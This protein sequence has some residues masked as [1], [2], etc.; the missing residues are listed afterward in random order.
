MQ[1]QGGVRDLRQRL[2]EVLQEADRLASQIEQTEGRAR[3]AARPERPKLT[4]IRGGRAVLVAPL[5]WV[6]AQLRDHASASVGLAAAG[7]IGVPT[8]LGVAAPVIHSGAP[9]VSISPRISE[10]VDPRPLPVGLT[11]SP[12][13]EPTPTVEVVGPEAPPPP[14]LPAPTS[15]LTPT[16]TPTPL[17]T[18]GPPPEVVEPVEEVVWT[19]VTAR[20]HCHDVLQADDLRECVEELLAS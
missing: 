20:A 19:R 11:P 15:A 12:S 7:V 9:P 1:P 16:P 10:D 6:W 13:S 5:V 4:L 18:A 8:A 3:H 17:P 2:R 14:A